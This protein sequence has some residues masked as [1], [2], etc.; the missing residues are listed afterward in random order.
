MVMFRSWL[1]V[2]VVLTGSVWA[3]GFW[4]P[5]ELLFPDAWAGPTVNPAELAGLRGPELWLD[6][7]QIRG[8]S[9]A[10]GGLVTAGPV[11]RTR[12]FSIGARLGWPE[13]YAFYAA[14]APPPFGMAL[15]AGQSPLLDTVEAAG[16]WASTGVEWGLGLGWAGPQDHRAW[17]WWFLGPEPGH[18]RAL[19][20]YRLP[21]GGGW[22]LIEIRDTFGPRHDGFDLA[23][24]YGTERRSGE[25]RQRYVLLFQPNMSRAGFGFQLTGRYELRAPLWNPS[26]RVL[27]GG[28]LSARAWVQH[29]GERRGLLLGAGPVHLHHTYEVALGNSLLRLDLPALALV[30]AADEV[31]MDWRV[32][33]QARVRWP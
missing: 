16:G 10:G 24:S 22:G 13:H 6:Q 17:L 11:Y 14:Y 2:G 30:L 20:G 4:R 32:A 26:H 3:S 25:L 8:S 29:E 7:V 27:F 19:L 1:L 33:L 31:R 9:A 12:R 23:L 18:H 15:W 5:G 28:G 21:L